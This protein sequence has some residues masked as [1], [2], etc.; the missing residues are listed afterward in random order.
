MS[1][2]QRLLGKS[3]DEDLANNS[4]KIATSSYLTLF[5]LKLFLNLRSYKK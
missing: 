2:Y 3:K 1:H 4:L 5:D